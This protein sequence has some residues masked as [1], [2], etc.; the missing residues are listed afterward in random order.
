MGLILGRWTIKS[1]AKEVAI[2]A[3]FIFIFSNIISYIRKPQLD[4]NH[5]PQLEVKLLDGTL[6]RPKEAKPLLVHFWATWCPTCKLEASNIE[7]LSQMYEVLTVAV[8]SGEAEKIKAYMQKNNLTF[9][10]LNDKESRWAKQFKVEAYPTTFIYDAMGELKFT[11]VGYT[12]TAG[13]IA[14]VKISE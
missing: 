13:L 10:V 12:T 8:N 14:R 4:S 7:Y 6:Y 2:G 5:L 3:I 11:E 1:I 9:R